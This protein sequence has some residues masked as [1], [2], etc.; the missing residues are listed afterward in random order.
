MLQSGSAFALVLLLTVFLSV[1]GC[2]TLPEPGTDPPPGAKA[3]DSTDGGED[4]PPVDPPPAVD[5][6][7][8]FHFL[9]STH[10]WSPDWPEAYAEYDVFVANPSLTADNLATIR[11]D[12]PGAMCLA[13]GSAQD[14]PIHVY[15]NNPYFAA[16]DAAFD[17]S[18]C[19]RNLTTGD[20]VRIYGAEPGD[21]G[22]GIP[23]FIVRKESADALVAFHRDVTMAAGWDGLYVDMCTGAYPN[24]KLED[25]LEIA[26]NF[27]IDDDGVGDHTADLHIQYGTWR[28]YFTQRLREELGSQVVI[29]GNSGGPLA[30]A[31][32]NGITLEGVGSRFTIAEARSALD[33][34]EA[35]AWAPFLAVLWATTPESEQPS[36]D[37]A[38][39]RE[40]VHF[41]RVEGAF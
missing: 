30:D 41:G 7:R 1:G 8:A 23:A 10:L 12:I 33:G 9:Q 26:P 6:P 19:I 3:A 20:V 29:V 16:L 35:A 21:P 22:A 24:W 4:D 5:P 34:A 14:V 25:L 13:S 36:L 18:L 15:P 37:L 2:L 40:G 39:E 32:L 28:P 38:A 27:D 17:S 11:A 31:A